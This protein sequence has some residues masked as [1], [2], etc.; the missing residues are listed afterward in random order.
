MKIKI[1]NYS[2]YTYKVEN[3]FITE[4]YANAVQDDNTA[5][6][7]TIWLH[8]IAPRKPQKKLLFSGPATKA[9]PPLPLV[10]LVVKGTFS[11]LFVLK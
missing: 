11:F 9:F 1:Y 10:G 3:V 8:H 6:T 2:T 4:C 7:V 5:K